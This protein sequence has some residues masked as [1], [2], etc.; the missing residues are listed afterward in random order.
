MHLVAQ[1]LAE[2]PVERRNQETAATDVG[3][4]ALGQQAQREDGP[5]GIKTHQVE[6]RGPGRAPHPEDTGTHALDHGQHDAA[7]HHQQEEIHQ[8]EQQRTLDRARPRT[9]RD[10]KV[11]EDRVPDLPQPMRDEQGHLDVPQHDQHEPAKGDAGMHVAQHLVAFPEL[12]V[13]QAVQE[14]VLDILPSR[15]RI[16]ERKQETPPVLR[17]ELHQDLDDP[18]AAI[19]QHE[20]HPEK[21]GQHKGVE[22]GCDAVDHFLSSFASAP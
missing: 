9:F 17:G 8:S 20:D 21:E 12:D 16:D 14:D 5:E 2:H 15:Y 19:A 13:Q 3:G 11:E 10:E 18:V 1:E 4:E 7:E 22:A 6:Q